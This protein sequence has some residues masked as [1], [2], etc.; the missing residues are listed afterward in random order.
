LTKESTILLDGRPA[1]PTELSSH[2]G[3]PATVFAIPGNATKA[4]RIE[5]LSKK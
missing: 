5:V 2:V 3:S 4:V 1:T